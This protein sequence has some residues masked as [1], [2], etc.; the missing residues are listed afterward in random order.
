MLGH[1]FFV[2]LACWSS[3]AEAAPSPSGGY[4]SL[5]LGH[6][7]GW[8]A[9]LLVSV[10]LFCLLAILAAGCCRAKR[11]R[12]TPFQASLSGQA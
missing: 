1:V 6:R 10:G 8:P 4:A 11:E 3:E 5:P 2:Y 12:E 9:A 7:G